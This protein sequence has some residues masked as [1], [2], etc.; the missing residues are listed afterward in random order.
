MNMEEEFV[1]FDA[2]LEWNWMGGNL[3]ETVFRLVRTDLP[4][5][6]KEIFIAIMFEACLKVRFVLECCLYFVCI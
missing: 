4:I 2:R 5:L 1:Y 6:D 3:C